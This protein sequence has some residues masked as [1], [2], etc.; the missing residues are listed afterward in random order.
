MPVTG[1]AGGLQPS[2]PLT[3]TR[4]PNMSQPRLR[5]SLRAAALIGAVSV[6]LLSTAGVAHASAGTGS[7]SVG[8]SGSRWGWRH[9]L[10]D[11]ADSGMSFSGPAAS[12]SLPG[13]T[14]L[15]VTLPQSVDGSGSPSPE[16]SPASTESAT[17]QASEPAEP[18][19]TVTATATAT[20]TATATATAT[21]TEEPTSNDQLSTL[22]DD[23]HVLV[24]TTSLGLG[25]V[26]LLV[27]VHVVGGW[28][29]RG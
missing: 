9:S 11:L 3:P 28:G 12:A 1:E 21:V 27:A 16:E 15:D 25:L 5:A 14:S 2:R 24:T 13:G 6:G 8:P 20:E 17:A 18:V 10:S 22:D 26:V 23:L 7:S 29:R 19:A 4:H